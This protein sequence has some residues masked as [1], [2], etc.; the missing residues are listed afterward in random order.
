L[1]ANPQL[2]I[3]LAPRSIRL[4]AMRFLSAI[5]GRDIGYG[6]AHVAHGE[7]QTPVRQYE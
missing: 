4:N 5:A 2:P 6:C 3:Q 1:L 7:R